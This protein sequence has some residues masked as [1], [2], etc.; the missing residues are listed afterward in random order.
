MG[1]K[2]YERQK[3]LH[4]KSCLGCGIRISPYRA[5]K[6][7][8]CCNLGRKLSSV[9]KQKISKA[10]K[11]KLISRETREA[12]SRGHM[13]KPH[14]I[15]AS[16]RK[17]KAWN[18]KNRRFMVGEKNG[19]WRGGITPINQKIRNSTGYKLWREAVFERDN[20]TC[21]WCGQVGGSLNA[22]HIKPFSLFPELRLAI[23]NGRTLC[24]KCHETTDT[25]RGKNTR[26]QVSK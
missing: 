8:K 23:D 11:G 22:D 7:H 19:N 6:C 1:N 12:I 4:L 15:E 20:W 14:N 13:G 16:V 26:K 3:E 25:Y 18:E 17:L 2:L 21:M 9:A 10:H 5:K 24:V